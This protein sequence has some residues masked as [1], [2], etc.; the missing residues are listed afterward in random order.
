V[1]HATQEEEEEEEEE[2]K[3]QSSVMN[4]KRGS[5]LS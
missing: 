4:Y 2:S 1:V 3:T 5:Y